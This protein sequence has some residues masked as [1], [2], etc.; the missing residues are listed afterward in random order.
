LYKKSKHTF[1]VQELFSENS[2]VYENVE[3]D[4]AAREAAKW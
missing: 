4:G 1:Y 3:K 2:A